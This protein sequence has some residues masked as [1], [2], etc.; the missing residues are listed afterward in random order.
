M[1]PWCTRSRS[2]L[3]A[4]DPYSRHC[5]SPRERSPKWRPPQDR[6][7]AIRTEAVVRVNTPELGATSFTQPSSHMKGHPESLRGLVD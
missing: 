2:S 5:P 4:K 3:K 6:L 7:L 1:R